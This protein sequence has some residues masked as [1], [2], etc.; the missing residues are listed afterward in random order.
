MKAIMDNKTLKNFLKKIQK[1][2]Y[3]WIWLAGKRNGYGR[4]M[5]NQTLKSAHRLS[6][7]YYIGPIEGELLVC[8]KCDNPSCVNPKH[9]FLGTLSDNMQDC[10]KKKRYKNPIADKERNQIHCIKG[11]ELIKENLYN[12]KNGKRGCKLC[13]RIRDRE[14]YKRE[15]KR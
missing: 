3:C 5:V 8:H 10:I 15:G 14:R 2:N 6:Y 11:H 12:L 13:G 4:F 1:T 9:L 7:E